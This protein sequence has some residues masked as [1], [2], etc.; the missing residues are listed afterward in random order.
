VEEL[1]ADT[2]ETIQRQD[3]GDCR[4]QA[5]CTELGLI[6]FD[7]LRTNSSLDKISIPSTIS[8]NACSRYSSRSLSLALRSISD[9]LGVLDWLLTFNHRRMQS[10]LSC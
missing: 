9:K 2:L 10:L 8:A 7:G 3:E 6:I 4:P 1:G 5:G